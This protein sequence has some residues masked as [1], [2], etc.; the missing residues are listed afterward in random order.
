MKNILEFIEYNAKRYGNKPAFIDDKNEITYDNLLDASKRI[1]SYLSSIDENNRPV[2]V[3]LDKSVKVLP[4]MFGIVYSGNF[5]VIIDSE[6]PLE[7][8]EKIF[9]TLNPAAVITECKYYDNAKSLKAENV[10]IFNDMLKSDIYEDKLLKIRKAQIDTDPLY[11][12]YTSGSTGVPKGAV[13]SHRNVIAYSEWVTNCFNISSD[14][15]FG[16]QTPFYFSMSVTDIYST[17]RAGATL[18]IIPKQYFTFPIKLVEFLNEYKVNTIYWVPSAISIVANLKLFDFAKPNYLKTVLFAGEVMPTKQ[19]NYWIHNLD[20]DILYANLYGP[21][22]TTDICTYYVVDREFSDDEPLPIG[23]HCDNCNVF[24][25]NEKGEKADINEEG[26]LF[27]RGSF[28]SAGYYNNSEKTKAAFVQ[29]P[30]NSSYPEIVYK[31]GDLVK[32]NERGEIMYICRKDYQIKHMGYRIELGE[33]ETAASS[34]DGMQE[35]VCIYDDVNDKI[36]L[37]YSARK[38][39]DEKIMKELSSKLNSYLM[40][41]RLIKMASLPHNQNGKIDRKKLKE[42]I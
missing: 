22:E 7:R 30:L 14:T 33:I 26:E 1:G 34:L 39:N 17:I 37:I 28:L 3:Y 8:I 6:M 18:V 11:A 20:S 38:T 12:L 24:I 2:A 29:N 21:T 16:N 25:V 36:I 42:L 41:N 5:Y 40:P 15:V 31:T 19:L 4:A 13:I 23:R 27:V 32:E 9:S 10:F 35:S